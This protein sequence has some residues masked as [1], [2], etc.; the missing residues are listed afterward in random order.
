MNSNSTDNV[1]ESLWEK[2]KSLYISSLEEDKKSQAELYFAQITRVL[3]EDNTL[4]I[5]TENSF[6]AELLQS[7]Y[8]EKIV[9]LLECS[10]C[11]T[12]VDHQI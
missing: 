7:N 8:A 4:I 5:K 3:R 10:R 12:W 11:R 2:A 9:V 6:A 1:S